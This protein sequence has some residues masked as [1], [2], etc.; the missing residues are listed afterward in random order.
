MLYFPL[1]A[2]MPRLQCKIDDDEESSPSKTK[3]NWNPSLTRAL[4]VSRGR[5]K[6]PWR[7]ASGI[8][9]AP[10]S[11]LWVNLMIIELSI[12][13]G[14]INEGGNRTKHGNKYIMIVSAHFLIS[15]TWVKGHLLITLHFELLDIL[16]QI[17]NSSKSATSLQKLFLTLHL[18][19][20]GHISVLSECRWR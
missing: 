3:Q 11:V 12:K 17:K 7:D 13:I 16:T 19:W 2:T 10:P 18:G 4:S 9:I 1:F 8:R 5:K 15:A 20:N 14:Q 6:S